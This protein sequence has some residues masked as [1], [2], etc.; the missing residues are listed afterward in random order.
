MALQFDFFQQLDPMA[1]V[2]ADLSETRE[3]LRKT[4]RKFFA[5]NKELVKIL[6]KQQEEIDELNNRITRLT[7]IQ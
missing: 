3:K 5:Q 1:D 2:K 6:L 4:Q 7:K